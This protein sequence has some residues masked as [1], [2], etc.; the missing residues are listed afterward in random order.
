MIGSTRSGILYQLRDIYASYA[1]A[2]GM[3]PYINGKFK[4]GKLISS[5]LS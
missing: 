5:L 3:L 1:C 2:A 4:I